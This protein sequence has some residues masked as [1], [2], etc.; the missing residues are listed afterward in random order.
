M[1]KETQFDFSKKLKTKRK[2]LDLIDQKLLTLLNHRLRIALEIGKIKKEM[3]K[4]IYDPKR[5]KEVLER[6]KRKDKGLLKE[7]DFKKIFTTIMKVCR[8]SQ[9]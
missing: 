1:K 2:V 7:E 6:L 5:E 3:G 4:K 8:K 9:L